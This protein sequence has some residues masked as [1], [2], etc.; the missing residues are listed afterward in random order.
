MQL[1]LR[2]GSTIAPSTALAASLALAL[3]SPAGAEPRVPVADAGAQAVPM[4]GGAGGVGFDDLAFARSLRRV[5]A[6]AG[7]TGRLVLVDPASRAPTVIAGFAASSKWGGGHDEGVTSADEGRGFV[8]ATDRT[9]KKLFVVDP[10]AMKIVASAAL[11]AGPDYVR[12]VAATS[13]VWVTE[14]DADRIEVFSLPP[15][16]VP[17]PAHA[18]SIPV[19]GGPESLVIDG[20]RNRAYTHLWKAK[21]IAIDL[22][23][24][25]TAAT[26]DNGC[27]DSR[28]IA[29]DEERGWLIAGC[30]EGKATLLDA[31]HDGARLGA[32][33]DGSGVDVIAYNPALRH[34]YLPGARSRTMAIVGLAPTGAPTLL[35]RVTTAAGAHCVAADDL[36]NAWVCDP[37]HG[38]LLLFH[39]PYPASK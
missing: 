21:T 16:G 1:N 12:F 36:G 28:G 14:P 23:T 26:W 6:P 15:T 31:G 18:A 27:V 7:R 3:A 11:A 9:A 5:L 17:T 4:P 39:D 35:G 37:A 29:L 2:A 38:Q 32:L 20:K 13:E 34:V 33:A 22:R 19:P 30:A 24:R 10:A 8:F 25:A